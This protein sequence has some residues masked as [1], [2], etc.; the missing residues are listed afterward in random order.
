MT[1]RPNARNLKALEKT[2]GVRAAH[3]IPK[4]EIEAPA[5]TETAMGMAG[6]LQVARKRVAELE[7]KGA[8][9]QLSVAAIRPN[10]WQPRLKFDAVK[11]QQLA[12]SIAETG[13]LQ[14]VVV[15]RSVSTRD[16]MVEYELVAGEC[17]LRAHKLLER[18]EIKAIVID[19]ADA[20]MAAL[21]LAENI[22]RQDLTDYEIGKAIRRADAEFP[23]RK[24]LAKALG[25]ARQD[26]YRYLTFDALPEF[27]KRDLD[28]APGLLGR[29][30]ADALVRALKTLGDVAKSALELNWIRLKT[31]VI[32]QQRLVA[33]VE[34][35]AT[36]GGVIQS[37]R[38][39]RKLFMG[40]GQ[41]GSITKDH[42]MLTLKLK[43]NVLSDD[44]EIALRMFVEQQLLGGG[45]ER[46]DKE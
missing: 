11:L 42:K 18:A 7:A 34:A 23:S 35:S 20:D 2:A 13:L 30:S 32:G 36:S 21:A 9:T 15:R 3:D 17:R 43:A 14:P 33:V 27:V 46:A 41:V 8:G 37:D 10:P 19:V 44:Q 1:S 45:L 40:T 31:G 25:M 22:D 16:T 4:P 28:S 26:L 12:D 39:I 38:D 6:A 5:R 24:D 29:N